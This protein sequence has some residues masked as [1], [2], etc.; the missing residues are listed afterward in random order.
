MRTLIKLIVNLLSASFLPPNDGAL[1]KANNQEKREYLTNCIV[2]KIE[3]FF[4]DLLLITHFS[5]LKRKKNLEKIEKEFYFLIAKVALA[6]AN[7]EQELKEVLSR[8]WDV[9]ETFKLYGRKLRTRFL[10]VLKEGKL[11]PEFY[12][13]YEALIN[14]FR[15]ASEKRNNIIKASYIVGHSN[16]FRLVRGVPDDEEETETLK[17]IPITE[18]RAVL[19]DLQKINLDL[20]MLQARVQI[21][22]MQLRIRLKIKGNLNPYLQV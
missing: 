4:K 3:H 10:E 15:D 18:L 9:P 16:V 5:E 7:I 19:K 13:E 14:Q 6:H 8:D 11:P 20:Y 17:E 1:A 2:N 12:L 21:D 22:K